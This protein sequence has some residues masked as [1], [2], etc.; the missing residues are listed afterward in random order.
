M[1]LVRALGA[2]RG[3]RAARGRSRS[4]RA[5]PSA[6]PTLTGCER[7]RRRDGGAHGDHRSAP[8]CGRPA[9]R[10]GPARRPGEGAGR[11]RP[12]GAEAAPAAGPDGA[13]D[14]PGPQAGPDAD[15]AEPQVGEDG[16]CAVRRVRLAGAGGR[17]GRRSA[18][19]AR[20]CEPGCR[21]RGWPCSRAPPGAR[22]PRC[23]ARCWP[24]GV[25]IAAPP[26]ELPLARQPA[27]VPLLMVLRYAAR[28]G[29]AGRRR[30][31]GA[32][33][34]PAGLGRPDA[35]APAAP[36]PAA[37]AGGGVDLA[38]PAARRPDGTPQRVPRARRAGRADDGRQGGP[39]RRCRPDVEPAE[40]LARGRT[41]TAVAGA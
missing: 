32:A 17:L 26:D 1:E 28:P 36:R 9:R 35:D 20:T 11:R 2:H 12:A 5:R 41:A 8:R 7:R 27:V 38:D 31:H 18:R 22:C 19:G 30:R 10:S 14:A 21:G 34:L 40:R 4:G 16:R 33:H 15:A 24:P 23:A 25:P 37:P 39:R 13:I 3:H 29:R 6:A